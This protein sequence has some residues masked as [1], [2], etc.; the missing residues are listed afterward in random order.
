MDIWQ[1]SPPASMA[2]SIADFFILRGVALL[3]PGDHGRWS[4]SRYTDNFAVYDWLRWF[5]EA[6]ADGDAILLRTGPTQ[7]RAVGLVVGGYSYEDRFD[8]V[9]G[10]DLQHCRRVRWCRLP[11][12]YEFG[13]PVFTRGRFSR[14]K[15]GAVRNYVRDFIAS[16]PT[17][18]QDV[19]LPELPPEEP[20]LKEIP[21]SLEGL[22]GQA[23][24]LSGLFRDMQNFGDA[25]MEDELVAHFVVPLLRCLGWPPECIA[26]KWRRVD[27]AVFTSLPRTPQNCSLVIEAKRPGADVEDAL[28]Q[29]S[30]Y[31]EA[32]GVPRNVVV[33]DGIRYRM[34][35]CG[36]GFA[37]LAYANLT[38]L[39]HSAVELFQRMKKP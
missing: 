23:Q 20:A 26:V 21:A 34:Y 19:A 24:D 5:A 39:K 25:P 14:V 6:M 38:R 4:S 27:V 10:F 31:V 37:P 1:I 16:P 7:I 2:D 33:T 8:D 32:L 11:K 17:A 13:E 22:V 3:W 28:K 18:W 15:K 35:S 30:Q 9:H 12:D 29:A 36:D